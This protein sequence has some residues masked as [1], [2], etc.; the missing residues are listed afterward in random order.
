MPRAA[1]KRGIRKAEGCE[2]AEAK[3]FMTGR[4]QAVRLPKAYRVSGESVHVKRLGEGIL[5]LPKAGERWKGL[6]AALDE[7]PREF[8]LARDQRQKKRGGLEN[9]FQ[10]EKE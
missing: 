7:F 10:A 8:D 9:L 3:V 2:T 4:S 1:R 5:L 6:F